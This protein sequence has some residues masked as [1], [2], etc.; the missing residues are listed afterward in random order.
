M[1]CVNDSQVWRVI[2]G[3]VETAESFVGLVVA[4]VDDLLLFM[5]SS[6]LRVALN[7]ALRKLWKLSSEQV[8][9]GTS[10]FMFLGLELQL[11]PSGDLLVHQASFV[12]QLLS[13]YGLDATAKP[14]QTVVIA[15]PTAADEIP[16]D[17]SQLKVLQKYAGEFNWLATR[18][19]PDLAYY[20]SLL[21]SSMKTGGEWTH[22]KK[23]EQ[24]CFLHIFCKLSLKKLRKTQN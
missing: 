6:S 15:L 11:R 3:D 16:P 7:D 21:A 10:P 4:Y 18:T 5:P 13:S 20:T 1:Q 9:D 8:F 24:A 12:R 17:P 14:N 2:A 22:H 23:L 19:R